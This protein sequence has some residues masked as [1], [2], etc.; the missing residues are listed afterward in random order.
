MKHSYH[1]IKNTRRGFQQELSCKLR[2]WEGSYQGERKLVCEKLQRV[3][4][5]RGHEINSIMPG[6]LSLRDVVLKRK[7]WDMNDVVGA[8]VFDGAILKIA[9][10]FYWDS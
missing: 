2:L 6:A 8:Q 4:Y 10:N 7:S 9:E 1:W 3:W 5:F